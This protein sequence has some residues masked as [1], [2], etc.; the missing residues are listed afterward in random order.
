MDPIITRKS[1]AGRPPKGGISCSEQI[2][3]RVDPY[4]NRRLNRMAKA[5]GISRAEI[6]RQSAQLYLDE[7]ER[8]HPELLGGC[9][10][11]LLP[12]LILNPT[13]QEPKGIFIIRENCLICQPSRHDTAIMPRLLKE[14][15]FFVPI[16]Q[17]GAPFVPCF[18]LTART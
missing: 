14:G 15:S 8:Q 3:V 11:D 7:M 17:K 16:F 13:E 6:L 2:K 12:S 18:P 1:N 9:D 10:V 4:L 5:L